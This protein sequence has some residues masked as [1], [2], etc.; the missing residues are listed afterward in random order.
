MH[1]SR[2]RKH[3]TWSP[4]VKNV[5]RPSKR[6]RRNQSR[7]TFSMQQADVGLDALHQGPVTAYSRNDTHSLLLTMR[8]NVHRDMQ[9]LIDLPHQRIRRIYD[10]TQSWTV[11]ES[12]LSFKMRCKLG[13][14]KWKDDNEVRRSDARGF[15]LDWLDG[16]HAL[17]VSGHARGR[18]THEKRRTSRRKTRASYRADQN[19]MRLV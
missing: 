14:I 5:S 6:R 13:T 11:H 16:V 8:N 12:G 18:A 3:V 10:G 9:L 17:H 19:N 7:S 4:V 2:R 15:R 1:R